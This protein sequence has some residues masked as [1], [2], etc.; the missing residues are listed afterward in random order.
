MQMSGCH[1]CMSREQYK[2]I[3]DVVNDQG[4]FQTLSAIWKFSHV[5]EPI[6]QSKRT[7]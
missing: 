6:Q 1:L 2:G 7:Y 3:H 4:R 5:R